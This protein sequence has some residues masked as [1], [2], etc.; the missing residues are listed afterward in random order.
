MS[1]TNDGE[2]QVLNRIFTN[3]SMQVTAI[4]S[5]ANFTPGTDDF[6][7]SLHENDPGEAGTASE[8]TGSGD[9]YERKIIS[10][11]AL[12]SAGATNTISNAGALT[13]SSI[14]GTWRS[15][16]NIGYFGIHLGSTG[17][18]IAKGAFDGGGAPATSGDTVSIAI[19]AID[20][21]MD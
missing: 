10:F 7:I 5:G 21:T 1:F 12:T 16:N 14:G 6:Y 13:W 4:N 19:G 2:A 18:M 3:Q 9:G 17:T 20:I 8:P 11:A 15:G